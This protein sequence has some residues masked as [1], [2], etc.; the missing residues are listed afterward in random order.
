MKKISI[1]IL[2]LFAGALKADSKDDAL[3]NA[4]CDF[5]LDK[6]KSIVSAGITPKQKDNALNLAAYCYGGFPEGANYLLDMGADPDNFEKGPYSYST[7]MWALRSTSDKKSGMKPVLDRILEKVK[8][9]KFA[10][11]DT[12]ETAL[13]WAASTGDYEVIKIL[14]KKGANPKAKTAGYF[15]DVPSTP[16]DYARD[17]GFV[18]IALKLE[19][20][21]PASYRT[22]LHYFARKGDLEKVKEMIQKGAN[23][24]ETEPRSNYT[25][26]YYAGRYNHL[27]VLKTLLAAGADPNKI[28]PAGTTVLRETVVRRFDR[29]S[30]A[31]IDGGAK[32]DNEQTN[33]CGT[34][35]T[36]FSWA[37]NRGQYKLARYMIDKKA[38]TPSSKNLY[39]ELFREKEDIKLAEYLIE[40]QILPTHEDLD[41]LKRLKKEWTEEKNQDILNRL[42]VLYE[43]TLDG[44]SAVAIKSSKQGA[45]LKKNI[46]NKAQNRNY[47]KGA[48]EDNPNSHSLDSTIG[49]IRSE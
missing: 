40:N 17:E 2:L 41:T 15:G 42:I 23:V 28:F 8:D 6:L 25:P 27:E 5:D 21:N 43:K 33:G 3:Q 30:R 20:K 31:L 32:A 16:A 37:Y 22:T 18:E 36:E 1:I 11:I 19:G 38:V 34:G 29:A 24:N 49:R 13:H 10:H 35:M 4:V 12:K 9:V 46:S 7:L 39:R 14:L 47:V 44:K 48:N 26:L 45:Y